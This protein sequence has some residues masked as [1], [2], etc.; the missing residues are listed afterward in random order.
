MVCFVHDRQFLS[1][2]HASVN[3]LRQTNEFTTLTLRQLP[4]RC[5]SC[6]D[7]RK[8]IASTS[9]EPLLTSLDINKLGLICLRLDLKQCITA[10]DVPPSSKINGYTILSFPTSF[11]SKERA[12]ITNQFIIEKK[13]QLSS[14]EQIHHVSLEFVTST[15]SKE[16]LNEVV[17]LKYDLLAKMSNYLEAAQTVNGLWV[18]FSTDDQSRDDIVKH[19]LQKQW[20]SFIRNID[21]YSVYNEQQNILSKVKSNKCLG[22]QRSKNK[23]QQMMKKKETTQWLRT[24]ASET[25]SEESEDESNNTVEDFVE[26]VLE[27]THTRL[28]FLYSRFQNSNQCRRPRTHRRQHALALAMVA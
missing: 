26:H 4:K 24:Q 10:N 15:T 19:V 17:Q 27:S 5:C 21:Q 3:K 12:T 6:P 9:V 1:K 2:F 20:K 25:S 7:K 16:L 8:Q 23:H 18:I 22:L 13:D 11:Q 14:L 28:H